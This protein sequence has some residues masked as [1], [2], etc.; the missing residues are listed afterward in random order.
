MVLAPLLALWLGPTPALAQVSLSF[1]L[2]GV[3]IGLS[4]PVYPALVRVPGHPVYYDPHS[5]SNYFFYDGLYWVYQQDTWYSSGWYDGPWQQVGPEYVPVFVLRVPVRYYRRPPSYFGGWQADVA[6]RWGEHWGRVWEA[7]RSGW[8]RWDHRGSPAPAPLPSY[9][10]RY[11]GE[12]YPHAADQQHQLRAQHYRHE[13][14]EAV[15]RQ[16]SRT[17]HSAPPHERSRVAQPAPKSHEHGR[18]GSTGQRT[19]GR[20]GDQREKDR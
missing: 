9:Q 7:R 19:K 20:E 4:V 2:P 13:P 17:P 6:P 3:S 16:L 10:R 12:R 15:S 8:N 1:G 14:R 11:A 18:D 5:S